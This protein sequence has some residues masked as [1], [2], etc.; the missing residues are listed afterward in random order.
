MPT[1]NNTAEN[2]DSRAMY[3][4]PLMILEE[5]INLAAS[6]TG[7]D[8]RYIEKD[9]HVT[10][11]IRHSVYQSL[12]VPDALTIFQGGTALAK[13]GLLRRFSE[14][15]DVNMEPPK[16]RTFGSKL[17]RKLRKEIMQNLLDNSTL[18]LVKND[19]GKRYSL[20]IFEYPSIYP[21]TGVTSTTSGLGEVKI[22][23]VSIPKCPGYEQDRLITSYIGE[24]ASQ[25]DSQLL[26][27][28]HMLR[29]FKVKMYHPFVS[30]VDKLDALHWRAEKG[31][32]EGLRVRSRDIFDL[33]SLLR[34][35]RVISTIS[36]GEIAALHAYMIEHL[37]RS[38]EYRVCERPKQGF[39]MSKAFQT[40]GPA[41]EAL[42]ASYPQVR[43]FVYSN[44]DW[45][46]Y[47]DALDIIHGAAH[48]L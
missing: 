26:E 47:D 33:A 12:E 34:N 8:K 29:P 10:E 7:L 17:K 42:R 43:S 21:A 30:I 38:M 5:L 48:L 44:E 3:G 45:I 22:E 32:L 35:E 24:V 36:S 6:H 2:Y 13:S 25:S 19:P 16:D 37:P 46:E 23:F 28:Y 41:S 27:D 40:K 39:S 31:D 15:I 14:D 9:I 1:F 4:C 18:S 11:S 20:L